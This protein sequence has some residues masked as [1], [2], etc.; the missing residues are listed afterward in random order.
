MGVYKT[1]L[2]HF[3]DRMPDDRSD[4]NDAKAI[5]NSLFPHYH[6]RLV[7]NTFRLFLNGFYRN[8]QFI[9]SFTMHDD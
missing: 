9:M 5:E 6:L 8:Q 1:N 3:T 7:N 2:M 4:R